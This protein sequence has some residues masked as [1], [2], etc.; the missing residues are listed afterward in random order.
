MMEE[1]EQPEG[2]APEE[3]TPEGGPTRGHPSSRRWP[4]DLE[5]PGPEIEG[6]EELKRP[7]KRSQG[8]DPTGGV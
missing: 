3:E 6:L 4:A 5:A 8:S 1:P 7:K 2:E